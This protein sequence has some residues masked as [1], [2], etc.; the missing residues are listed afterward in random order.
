MT[1]SRTLYNRCKKLIKSNEQGLKYDDINAE[2]WALSGLGHKYVIPSTKR[3][4]Q[5]IYFK[6][7]AGEAEKLQAFIKEEKGLDVLKDPYMNG[8]RVSNA[9]CN[10]DEKVGAN[11]SQDIILVN[12][13]AGK[14]KLNQEVS[15][16]FNSIHTAG[17]ELRHS[18]ITSIEHDAI[19]ICENF[20]PMYYLHQ[21]KNNPVF[22]HALIIYRGDSQ[23][24]KRADEVNCFI[25][26]YK[27]ILPLY[28]FGDF[29]PEGFSIANT[30]QVDGIILPDITRFSALTKIE[31]SKLAGKDKF[32]PQL[33]HGNSYL[34]LSAYSQ[35]WHAHIN[36]MNQHQL[37]WQQEHLIGASIKFQLY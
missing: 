8:D 9:A 6:L 15:S 10:N 31:L 35:A 18:M 21:L 32:F 11:A 36:L 22:K 2:I 33:A 37:G 20:T 5:K 34:N 24:G 25:E 14:L 23:S 1:I 30:F 28:Y 16:L 7:R 17:L 29:D 27:A 3:T 12:N 4:K 19:I 13:A 26:K